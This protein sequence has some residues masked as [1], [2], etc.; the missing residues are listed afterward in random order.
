[1]HLI[2]A[3]P[4]RSIENELDIYTYRR[5]QDNALVTIYA[6]ENLKANKSSMCGNEQSYKVIS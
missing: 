2:Y 5:E 6:A 1:M 4:K 3:D